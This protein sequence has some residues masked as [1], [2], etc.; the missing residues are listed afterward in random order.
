M[1]AKDPAYWRERSGKTGTTW[2]PENPVLDRAQKK[3][4]WLALQ[5][6]IDRIALWRD[7]PH[8]MTRVLDIGC[9]D[10]QVAFK[11]AGRYGFEV[12]GCDLMRYVPTDVRHKVELIYGIDA[13]A[14]S[15]SVRVRNRG[16][17][18]V[19][20]LHGVLQCVSNWK[21]A[22]NHAMSV[23]QQIIVLEDLRMELP[24]YFKN[25]RYNVHMTWSEFCCFVESQG[26]EVA[27]WTAATIVDRALVVPAPQWL[28]PAAVLLSELFDVVWT[29][30]RPKSPR[31]RFR[32][33][34]LRR[35]QD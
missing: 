31:A 18:D 8:W 23:A 1:P 4:Y 33:V 20:V 15:Q 5:R 14:V 32:V 13:E 25:V 21:K 29:W 9:G 27:D 28:K 19:V 16:P 2:Y 3:L 11:L 34:F 30:L 12:V 6:L 26:W 35:R 24:S 17:Y 22:L 10:G 7:K